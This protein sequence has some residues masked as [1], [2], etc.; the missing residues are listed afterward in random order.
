MITLQYKGT[1]MEKPILK[2]KGLLLGFLFLFMTAG[3]AAAQE[4]EGPKGWQGDASLSLGLTRGNT[5]TTTLSFSAG[6]KKEWSKTWALEESASFMMTRVYG[7]T[8]A[9][10][11]GL[12]SRVSHK[13]SEKLFVFGEVQALRDRFKNYSYRFIPQIG[14]GFA[15]VKTERISLDFTAGLTQVV[16]RYHQTADNDTYT[17]LALGNRW[18]WKI[19][20]NAELK[21]SLSFNTD[22]SQLSRFFLR[23]E[24]SLI[25]SLTKL[26]AVK[27]TLIDSYDNRPVGVGI[28]KNDLALL[29]GLSLKF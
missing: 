19:G 13:T 18:A 27:L 11:M 7:E 22:F 28:K 4:E 21:E 15:A 24:V 26:L 10:N 8:T 25:S 17:G 29:A 1:F 16:T 3:W 2:K 5:D 14:A 23:L 20:E 12:T 6:L 9:E